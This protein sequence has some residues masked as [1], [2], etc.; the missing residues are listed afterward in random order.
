MSCITVQFR[1]SAMFI[2]KIAFLFVMNSAQAMTT[3]V[4]ESRNDRFR[5]GANLHET[6]LNAS[7][8]NSIKFGQIFSVQVD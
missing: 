2:V 7:N 4:F 1:L 8:V 6:M 3:G 5:S